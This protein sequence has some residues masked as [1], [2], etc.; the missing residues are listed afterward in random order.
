MSVNVSAR[1][2]ATTRPRRATVAARPRATPASTPR[3]LDARDHRDRADARHRRTP[4][5]PARA[6][7]PR[8]ARSRS[9]TSAPATRRSPTCSSS[10]S[11]SLK[12]GRLVRRTMCASTH[13]C[14]PISVR[15]LLDLGDALDLKVVA[16]EMELDRGATPTSWW[17]AGDALAG[18]R[19][20]DRELP[21]RWRGA[22]GLGYD[23]LSAE[24]PSVVYTS[25]AGYSPESVDARRPG[26]DFAIQARPAGF[27]HG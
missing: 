20:G 25:I 1:Q 17:S 24:R 23:A 21:A 14:S 8:R 5:T 10:R 16:E 15:G 22:P 11:T 13:N 12:I 26:F 19:R 9:T 27:D 3:L 7:A 6:Q 2:L 18:V 4:P